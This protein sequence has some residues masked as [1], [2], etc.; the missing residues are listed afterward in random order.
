M[1]TTQ[2]META[3][4]SPSWV[5][6]GDRITKAR[7]IAGLDVIELAEKSGIHRNSLSKYE[8]DRGKPPRP[9]ML[10]AIAVA[11]KVSYD[12]LASGQGHPFDGTD[13]APDL[14]VSDSLWNL[15]PRRLS[16]LPAAS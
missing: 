10:K 12:W 9:Y 2:R 13:R 8:N 5:T 15:T 6:L 16:A 7:K 4:P 3:S 11:C 14:R 1:T